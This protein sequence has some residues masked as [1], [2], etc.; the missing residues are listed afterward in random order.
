MP[1]VS[2]SIRSD[3]V[4][5]LDGWTV[6]KQFSGRDEYFGDDDI[7]EDSDCDVGLDKAGHSI[8]GAGGGNELEQGTLSVLSIG[9]FAR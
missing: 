4:P 5:E 6:V 9:S 1:G 3:L 7:F 2:T 8:A